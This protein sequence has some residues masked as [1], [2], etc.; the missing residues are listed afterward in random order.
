MVYRRFGSIYSILGV[1]SKPS[2]MEKSIR[3]LV[4][5]QNPEYDGSMWL[6]SVIKLLSYYL[7]S[8]SLI[9]HSY[10]VATPSTYMLVVITLRVLLTSEI[11]AVVTFIKYMIIITYFEINS[12]SSIR[13]SSLSPVLTILDAIICLICFDSVL[14]GPRSFSF[15]A[16]RQHVH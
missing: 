9:L 15:N 12:M 10:R 1:T 11:R 7:A 14:T 13:A 2:N 5:S 3:S 8:H 4:Y 6:R 16:H